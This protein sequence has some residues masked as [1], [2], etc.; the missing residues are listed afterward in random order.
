ML[1]EKEIFPCVL[2]LFSDLKWL[3]FQVQ[4]TALPLVL[5]DNLLYVHFK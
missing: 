5:K 2:G 4:R 3:F 1:Y